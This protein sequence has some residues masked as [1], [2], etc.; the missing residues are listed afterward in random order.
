MIRLRFFQHSPAR[1]LS[2]LMIGAMLC[3]CSGE[4]GNLVTLADASDA[5]DTVR[6]AGS[7]EAIV[8]STPRGTLDSRDLTQRVLVRPRPPKIIADDFSTLTDAL[9]YAARSATGDAERVRG[10]RWTE[11]AQIGLLFGSPEGKAFLSGKQGRALVRGEPAQSCP[12]LNVALAPTD[13][14]ATDG[15]MR[16]CLNQTASLTDCGCRLIARGDHL[17]A[18]RDDFAYAIGVGTTV[19]DPARGGAMTYASEERVVEGRPGARHVWLLDVSGPVGLL[20]VE[21]DGRA[22]MTINATGERFNGTHKADGFRRGRTA[23]R[24]Y[25]TAPDGRNVIVLVGFEDAEFKENRAQLTAWNPYGSLV[26]KKAE[27][28]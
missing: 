5:R 16:A 8:N 11:A 1:T 14:Q 21:A 13:E 17:L 7:R 10:A 20:Q 18:K 3:A 25:L 26:L 22:A 2:A 24:A 19:I 23:R 28:E 27:A 6:P 9:T 15:A 12:M 4:A